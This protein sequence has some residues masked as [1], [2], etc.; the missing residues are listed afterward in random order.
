MVGATFFASVYV[1]SLWVSTW[2][3]GDRQSWIWKTS[4]GDVRR[5]LEL[6]SLHG[7]LY[8]T[9]QDSQ[10]YPGD[11]PDFFERTVTFDIPKWAASLS[12]SFAHSL[13]FAVLVENG[14][15]V[16]DQ[17]RCCCI[18]VPHWALLP[19]L[20]APFALATRAF[21]KRERARFR[22]S[23][24]LCAHCG[25]DIRSNTERCPECGSQVSNGV[26]EVQ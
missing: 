10:P 6:R 14:H 1:A 15:E 20:G 9:Y 23:H 12:S 26:S 19:C 5:I 7:R 4:P 16:N 11:I 8:F 17:W 25:Y 3:V 24:G 22:A 21:M 2:K 18:M 13:G